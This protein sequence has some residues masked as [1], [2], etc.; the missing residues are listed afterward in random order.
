MREGFITEKVIGVRDCDA[1]VQ[2][3][4]NCVGIT[5]M[6]KTKREKSRYYMVRL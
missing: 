6:Y 5:G 3:I 2:R 1:F 4:L